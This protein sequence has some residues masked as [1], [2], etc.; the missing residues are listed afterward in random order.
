MPTNLNLASSL[1]RNDN[2]RALGSVP[3]PLG[4]GSAGRHH[5]DAEAER[6]MMRILRRPR[7]RLGHLT[8]A[9]AM[10]VFSFQ[11]Q[12]ITLKS[13]DADAQA[14]PPT[15]GCTECVIVDSPDALDAFAA[16]IGASFRDSVATLKARVA[17]GCVVCLA[18]RP[19]PNGA[20]SL[21]VGYE[22]AERGVFSALG[23]RI[24]VSGDV[25]FSHYVEVLPEYRGQRIHRL[26]FS[27]RDN[28]FRQRQGRVVCGVCAP[29]NHA[30]LQALRRDGASI[31]GTVER[32]SVLR[33]FV[34]SYTPIDR[35]A[36]L[37]AGA[38]GDGADARI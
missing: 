14:P 18:R 22:I 7:T 27:T 34:L 25:V 38:E 37:F 35:I 12:F 24:R 30:S 19:R 21:V 10:S 15:D 23:R 26:L 13:L 8:R 31:V 2:V 29:H 33:V 17:R 1:Q 5:L 28:Y 3:E 20:G 9:L 4:G 11:R 36:Q 16:D 6:P 32:I